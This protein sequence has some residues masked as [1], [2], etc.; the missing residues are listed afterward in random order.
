MISGIDLTETIDFTSKSD[1]GEIK[2]VFTVSPVSSRIQAR[3]GKLAGADGGGAL[4]S[5]MEAFKFG[6]KDIKNLQNKQ[7]GPVR[8]KT[9]EIIVGNERWFVVA[10]DIID[11]LPLTVIIEVGAKIMSF[12]NLSEEEAKN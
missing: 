3:V 6:V 2:T 9:E 5:M 1:T 10:K 11:I 12:N 7:G 8:F 4:D